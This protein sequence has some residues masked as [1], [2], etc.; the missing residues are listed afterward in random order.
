MATEYITR[1]YAYT[2]LTAYIDL[3]VPVPLQD[4]RGVRARECCVLVSRWF[5]T[6]FQA[7]SMAYASSSVYGPA[8][9]RCSRSMFMISPTRR[10]G[11][12][13]R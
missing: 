1:V 11:F 2:A 4:T 3:L 13:P 12:R 6:A 9:M 5:Y 10:D 8:S 7:S